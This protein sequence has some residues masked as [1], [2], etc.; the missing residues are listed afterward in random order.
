MVKV[1]RIKGKF[2]GAYLTGTEYVLLVIRYT[3]RR[4]NKNIGESHF[5]IPPLTKSLLKFQRRFHGTF[6]YN[7]RWETINFVRT[8]PK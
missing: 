8:R 6:R 1:R 3:R 4:T 7:P 2:A 5:K